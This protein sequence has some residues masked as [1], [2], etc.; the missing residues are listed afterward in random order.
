MFIKVIKKQVLFLIECGYK[1]VIKSRR[2]LAVKNKNDKFEK[3]IIGKFNILNIIITMVQIEKLKWMCIL[4][5]LLNVKG[6]SNS[7][8]ET[9]TIV[10]FQVKEKIH[11]GT[12]SKRTIEAYNA[13]I[14]QANQLLTIKNPTVM[15]K[16]IVPP[17]GNKH[18]YLSISRY[19][20]P[21]PETKDGLPWIRK[22]G[23][24]NPE[25]QTDAV[26]RKRMGAMAKGVKYLSLAYYFT[27]DE[28]YAQKAVSILKA[29]FLDEATMMNPHLEFAQSVPGYSEGR[30]SGILDGK[31]IADV[32]PEAVTIL[33]KSTYWTQS[34]TNALNKWLTDYLIWLTDSEL[35]KKENSQKNNHGSWYK[36]QVATLALYLGNDALAK[37]T[38]NATQESINWQLDFEGKQIHELERTRSFFYSCYNLNALT[39]IAIIG[40]SVGMDMWNY[41]SDDNK[42]LMLAI[43]YLAPVIN[44]A[45][46]DYTE[47]H[48]VDLSG[49][50]FPLSR[51]ANYTSS[52]EVEDLFSKTV[53][54]LLEEEKSTGKRNVI[55]D[56]L[57]LTTNIDL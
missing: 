1:S 39:S 46:W 44:G 15:D 43:N 52:Q 21:N 18:D 14:K 34:D 4:F 10:L 3:V 19:W 35:G 2:H 33:S 8:I 13:L 20:W 23:E 31:S 40:D 56:E 45:L 26:D 51:M 42:N 50:V 11:N 7:I 6:F 5:I 53:L 29:W 17:T 25:T 41:T 28:R 27:G 57:C 54:I 49:L 32:V 30:S 47:I 22:D 24:T 55:L 36:Y 48:G 37:Q 38:V 12:A 16:S 9:D